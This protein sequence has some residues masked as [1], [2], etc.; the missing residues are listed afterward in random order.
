MAMCDPVLWRGLRALSIQKGRAQ[1][2]FDDQQPAKFLG[3]DFEPA[4]PGGG[5]FG[6]AGIEPRAFQNLT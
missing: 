4:G 6:D 2:I 3:R 5:S 1:C